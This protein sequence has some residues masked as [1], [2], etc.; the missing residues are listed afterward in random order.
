MNT[1]NLCYLLISSLLIFV[2]SSE[3][4]SQG[5]YPTREIQLV[6][7]NPAGGFIDINVRFM[8]DTLEKNLGVPIIVN[9]RT[10]AG[11]VTGTEYLIK[12]KPDGYTFGAISS[13]NVVLG[14]ATMSAL[15]YKY[16]D[17]DPLCKYVQDPT[18]L[19]CKGEA[20]WNTLEEL[21]ADG[22]KRPGQITYG[23]TTSS[24]SHF[25]ME[26][27]LKT[28]GVTMLHVPLP[29]AIDTLTRILGG[30]LDIGVSSLASLNPQLRAGTIRALFITTPERI[31]IF[32]QI[33]TLRERGYPVPVITLTAGFF[34][35][36]KMS[37][38]IRET[39]EKALDKT[40]NDPGVKKKLEEMGT[41]WEYLPSGSFAKEIEESYKRV[42]TFVKTTG[43]QK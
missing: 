17:L 18:I 24:V 2:F 43:S 12:S 11:G 42:I 10:G 6:I 1:R 38:S 21:V 35:P 20:P 31:S 5:K 8:K 9:N 28:S 26:D 40:I 39:L 23:A 4:L 25:V 30:N 27:F 16:S 33:P 37:K 19:F 22:K 32:P 15:P 29:G 7:P 3:A 36:P 34:V 41:V 14:P 13:A